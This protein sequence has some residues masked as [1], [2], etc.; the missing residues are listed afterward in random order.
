MSNKKRISFEIEKVVIKHLS[1]HAKKTGISKARY[2][3]KLIQNTNFFSINKSQKLLTSTQKTTFNFYIEPHI[4]KKIQSISNQYRVSRSS[5]IRNILYGHCYTKI[6]TEHK[7]SEPYLI[8]ESGRLKKL[9]E[10]RNK[11]FSSYNAYDLKFLALG[12]IRKGDNQSAQKI[13]QYMREN[14]SNSEQNKAHI[15][16]IASRL[17]RV[18]DTIEKSRN[19]ALE[20]LSIGLNLKDTSITSESYLRLAS[21]AIGEG[22]LSEGIDQLDSALEYANPFNDKWIIAIIYLTK[23]SIH[24]SELSLKEAKRV[25]SRLERLFSGTT[26]P[27]FFSYISYYK[28]IQALLT[29]D[30]HNVEIIYDEGIEYAVESSSELLVLL[31]NQIYGALNLLKYN[32]ASKSISYLS[33]AHKI[34]Q[35]YFLSDSKQ[36][37]FASI[38]VLCADKARY[39]FPKAKEEFKTFI[40]Y[41]S[42]L[43]EDP[44]LYKYLFGAMNYIYGSSTDVEEGEV[45]LQQISQSN[46]LVL[47]KAA[48]RTLKTKAF[49][50]VYV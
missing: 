49:S 50:P 43:G 17:N 26:H 1:E 22:K 23:I 19:N 36:H 46:R 3:N 48:I 41:Q 7:N 38:L 33:K 2:L 42:S 37:S 5:V 35:T 39:N 47:K 45:L 24:T 40:D 13:L 34:E 4:F 27:F 21:C 29:S 16:L 15:L 28:L 20:A 6:Q 44:I 18:L 31:L 14:Y 32:K 10:L 9:E 8:F 30:D 25:I 11:P 12:Y